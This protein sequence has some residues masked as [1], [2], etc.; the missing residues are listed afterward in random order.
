MM[1]EDSSKFRFCCFEYTLS[2]DKTKVTDI[3]LLIPRLNRPDIKV[4]LIINLTEMR[5]FF[6]KHTIPIEDRLEALNW[7]EK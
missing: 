2:K 7:H 4:E 3:S 6:T 5:E 1:N